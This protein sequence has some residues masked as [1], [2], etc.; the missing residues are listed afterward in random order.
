[1]FPSFVVITAL[2]TLLYVVGLAIALAATSIGRIGPESLA[3]GR[4]PTSALGQQQPKTR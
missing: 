3:L 4:A 2:V 1:V